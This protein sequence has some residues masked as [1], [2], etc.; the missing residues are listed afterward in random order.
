MQISKFFPTSG[1]G[2]T[3][4]VSGVTSA[5]FH[6][7]LGYAADSNDD[8]SKEIYEE[9]VVV[10]HPLSSGGLS[11]SSQVLYG[12]ELQEKLD[13][14][15]ASTLG[16]EPGI[17]NAGF[18]KAVGRPVIHGLGGP[19]VR[20]MVDRID[21]LDVSVTSADHAVAI[22][23][24][25]AEKVE[26][27]KGAST[28]L[29][30]S[31]AIGGAV[32]IE[33]NRIPHEIPE[34]QIT[35][36]IETRFDSNTNGNAT[37]AKLDGGFGKFAWHLDSTWKDGD[38]YDIPGFATSSALRAALGAEDGLTDEE[39]GEVRGRLPGSAFD[40]NDYAGG[41]SYIADW[42]FIG[43][44]FSRLEANYGLPGGGEG[45]EE[46]EEEP[47]PGQVFT[48]TATLDLDQ[49]R[50]DFELG[51]NEPFGIFKSFN[52]RVGVNDYEHQEIEPNGEVATRF[53]NE[54]WE[55]RG[56]LAFETGDYE[57][58]FGVQ[59]LSRDFSA[60][61]EEA[62]VPPVDTTDVGVFLVAQRSF[63]GFDLEAGIRGG[64][65]RQNP[66]PEGEDTDTSGVFAVS[67]G[68]VIPVS[69]ALRFGVNAD[70]S[71][72]APIAEE[73]FSNG[74]HIATQAFEVGDPDLSNE[75]AVNLSAQMNYDD[76]R[77]SASAT[78][79]YNS[80]QNF[81]FEQ[82]NGEIED[83]LPVFLFLQ[84]DASFFGV[85]FEASM[86]FARWNNG[87]AKIRTELDFVNADL[88][89][90]SDNVPRI[91]PLRYG[92]GV[93]ARFGILTTSV[94]YLRTT[95][96]SDVASNEFDTP[97]FNDLR[98][99]AGVEYEFGRALIE[100]FV[101]GK[102][103]TDDTQRSHTSFIK[104]FAPAPGRTVEAG[105]RVVF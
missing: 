79:Y 26:V 104:E 89:G 82:A 2:A 10:A 14:N 21:T 11:Q 53:S 74:P 15:I 68:A 22:E 103:L 69:D 76:D 72:R 16:N 51:I 19:R 97:S 62:F 43:A 7:S 84:E 73:L 5:I 80:F 75:R 35:G 78:V 28:L 50:V 64:Y 99:Y 9:I 45:E 18:G 77:W 34:N 40:F 90:T 54:A 83:G 48:E 42:G 102:N 3:F 1:A 67:L 49:N 27:L 8:T 24:F 12:A 58:A 17:R 100:A 88:S 44:A 65:V 37:S 60:I 85:D 105:L 98:A 59:V 4:V 46:E 38:D 61:G 39:R 33:T 94:D 101:V 23:P 55:A 57:G 63:E 70:Y 91:P 6:A 31:G 96:Q 71:S 30:G 56:E 13:T 25:V 20:I 87:E 92:A 29:Y 81:I 47:L 36:G 32:N 66:S 93:E 86:N 52:L 95:R 41:A